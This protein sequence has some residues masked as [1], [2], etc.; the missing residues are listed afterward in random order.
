MVLDAVAGNDVLGD[1]GVESGIQNGCR[2]RCTQFGHCKMEDAKRG[3]SL[4]NG[5]PIK[6][7]TQRKSRRYFP[8]RS[9]LIHSFIL[10]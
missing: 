2:L 9:F 7:P 4:A 1:Q 3:A 10:P 5:K 8:N 6:M